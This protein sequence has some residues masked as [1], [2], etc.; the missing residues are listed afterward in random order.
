[1]SAKAWLVLELMAIGVVL[2][3]LFIV[4]GEACKR[5]DRDVRS[6]IAFL[7]GMIVW[8]FIWNLVRGLP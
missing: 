7:F 1:M 2:C 6:L 3:F 4:F 8:G 5:R